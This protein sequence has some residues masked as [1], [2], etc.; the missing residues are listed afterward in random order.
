MKLFPLL[1]VMHLFAVVAYGQ[2]NVLTPEKFEQMQKSPHQLLDVRTATEFQTGYIAHAMQ[3]D[4]QQ[5]QQFAERTTYLRKDQPVLVYCASG[6][7][8][9]KAAQYL[10][11]KGYTVYALNGGMIEWKKRGMP[12][13]GNAGVASMSVTDFRKK[14]KQPGYV[15]V[16]VGAPWCPPCRQMIPTLDSLK[17]HR[18]NDFTLLLVDG[19]TDT[20]IVKNLQVGALPHF[21]LYKNG[22][23]VWQ[24]QGIVPFA[25]FNAAIAF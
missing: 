22:E 8:S 5:P 17:Q 6:V 4:W 15:L 20:E 13:T 12:V 21:F 25:T 19:G 23:L 11:G 1:L 2:V 10:A 9:A 3:A 16:D 24:Q 18:G 14:I 7:R